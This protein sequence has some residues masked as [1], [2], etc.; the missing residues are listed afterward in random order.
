MTPTL[1]EWLGG[2]LPGG[3]AWHCSGNPVSAEPLLPPENSCTAGMAPR[4]LRS[5]RH[6]RHCAR[7]ALR[8]LG[9]PAT[10]IPTDAQRAPVWPDGIVGSISHSRN[11]A[12]AVAA[13][14]ECLGGIGIDLEQPGKLDHEVALLICTASE[15]ARLHDLAMNDGERLLFS[16]KESIYKCLWPRVQRFIEFHEVDVELHPEDRSFRA[17]P[18]GSDEIPEL[19]SLTGHYMHSQALLG[20][21]SYLPPTESGRG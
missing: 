19:A 1:D 20:A 4:R 5:F 11:L 6:G 21:V 12:C 16:I 15:R 3:T 13:R 17:Q 8:K 18:V 9:L 10:A 14:T 7:T 2:I